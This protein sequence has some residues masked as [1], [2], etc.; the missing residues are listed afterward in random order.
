MKRENKDQKAEVMTQK[1]S[2]D[3]PGHVKHV[4]TLSTNVRIRTGSIIR[5]AVGI[6]P[7]GWLKTG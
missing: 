4:I 1:F 7:A 6:R 3:G 5:H 2:D